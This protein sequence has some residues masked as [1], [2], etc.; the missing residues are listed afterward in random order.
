MKREDEAT[1]AARRSVG[2]PYTP[3]EELDKAVKGF[4]DEGAAAASLK[5]AALKSAV[6]R[7]DTRVDLGCRLRLMDSFIIETTQW[8]SCKLATTLVLLLACPPE[9]EAMFDALKW[10]SRS[11]DGLP[12]MAEICSTPSADLPKRFA[13][14]KK[15]AIDGKVGK[16]T[17]LGV[18]LVDVEMLERGENKSRDMNYTSFAHSFILAIG[19]EGFRVYQSWGKH[20]Y[21]LDQYLMQGGSR[22]RPWTE[23]KS[24]LKRFRKLSCSTV[25]LISLES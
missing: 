13:E 21:R 18:S 8:N 25:R 14:A 11:L 4:F 7:G 3:L 15:T 19:R 10:Q 17:V 12:T 24:F 9:S 6:L 16:V 22:C 23:A 20:G 2:L 1:A 5:F